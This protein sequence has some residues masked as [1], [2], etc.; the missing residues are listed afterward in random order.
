MS[1]P[2]QVGD[3]AD[4][5]GRAEELGRVLAVRRLAGVGQVAAGEAVGVG[6]GIGRVVQLVLQILVGH[7]VAGNRGSTRYSGRCFLATAST[8]ALFSAGSAGSVT[9]AEP[10]DAP[11]R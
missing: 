10:S 1:A 5:A 7:D 9:R 11:S 3:A 8:A 2:R 4:D 6:V